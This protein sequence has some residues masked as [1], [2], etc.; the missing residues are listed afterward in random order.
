MWKPVLTYAALLAIGVFALEWME[1]RYLARAFGVEIF[2]VLVALAFAGLGAWAAIVLTGRVPAAAEF[3]RN[4][5]ALS[6]L[7]ITPREYQ[8]LQRLVTGG[9]NKQIARELGVSPNTVKTHAARL[10]EKLDVS[11]RVAAIEKARFLSLIP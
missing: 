6:S 8:V 11:G 7:A 5:A 1:Y 10:Y 4:E 9:S 2:L 3:E